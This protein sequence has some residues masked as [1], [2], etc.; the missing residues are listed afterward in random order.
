MR[1][2]ERTAAGKIRAGSTTKG[3]SRP[4]LFPEWRV[5][6]RQTNG[7]HGAHQPA[8][9]VWK[10][11][12][13]YR[14]PPPIRLY[15]SWRDR[16]S[17]YLLTALSAHHNLGSASELKNHLEMIPGPLRCT[18]FNPN[19]ENVCVSS[20]TPKVLAE[21]FGLRSLGPGPAMCHPST[22]LVLG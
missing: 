16:K 14:R 8:M 6:A 20:K 19:V 5:Y 21:N 2:L 22:P 13:L 3:K 11:R 10:G 17:H 15:C 4:G 18:A 12:L 1:F 9:R 7:E